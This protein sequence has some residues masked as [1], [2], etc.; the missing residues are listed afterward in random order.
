M[1]LQEFLSSAEEHGLNHMGISALDEGMFG[2]MEFRSE[3]IPKEGSECSAVPIRP[4]LR[5]R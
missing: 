2:E 4:E 3:V 1:A 5:R